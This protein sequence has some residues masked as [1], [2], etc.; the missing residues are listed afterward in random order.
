MAL[1]L[2]YH[3]GGMLVTGGT[4]SVGGGIVRALAKAGVPLVEAI[5]PRIDLEAGVVEVTPPAGLF[6]EIE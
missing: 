3:E 4:G 1:T 2:T 5:V 6:E